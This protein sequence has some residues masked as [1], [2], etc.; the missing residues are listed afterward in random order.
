[1]NGAM[2]MLKQYNKMKAIVSTFRVQ[3][4]ARAGRVTCILE[5]ND[6]FSSV[7]TDLK[8]DPEFIRA[9]PTQIVPA[10]QEC[11]NNALKQEVKQMGSMMP[12]EEMFGKD[13]LA[14]MMGNLKPPG[15]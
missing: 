4:T 7:V 1:M 15:K 13:G 11:I 14:S 12:Q 5:K 8:V 9:E 6:D 2:G 10:I 3:G